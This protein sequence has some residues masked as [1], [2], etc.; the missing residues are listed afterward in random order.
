MENPLIPVAIL[1]FCIF[2]YIA[3][4][5]LQISRR[6]SLIDS[7]IFPTTIIQKVM[8]K[9]PHL[10]ESQAAEVMDGLRDYFHICNQA[11]KRMV[12]MPS[13]AVDI[14]WH[15]FILF[16]QRYD[17]FCHRALGRFLHH[18][19]AEAMQSSTSAQRGIKRA[20]SIA[21]RRENISPRSAHKLPLLFAL[22]KKL[23][24]PDGFKYSLNCKARNGD[25][26]CATHIGCSSGSGSI[27]GGSSDSSSDGGSSGCGGGC[28]SS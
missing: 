22:D 3:N 17:Q 8:D 10:S 4:K 23:K 16:T 28:G 21:C 25:S 11:G 15:E 5:T 24:I 2:L 7:Y 27:F 19:P 18:T 20:W 9:Y 13:Q 12:S 26:Y 14:A 1:S 6:K